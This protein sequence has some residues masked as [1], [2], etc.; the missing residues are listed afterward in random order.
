MQLISLEIEKK[1][2][3]QKWAVRSSRV[4]LTNDSP[5]FFL[6]LSDFSFFLRSFVRSFSHSCSIKSQHTHTSGRR[7]THTQE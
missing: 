4:G 1:R 2:I 7:H 6:L 3:V 5:G